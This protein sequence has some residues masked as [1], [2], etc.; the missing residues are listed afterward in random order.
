MYEC[1]YVSVFMYVRV[2]NMWV[3]TSLSLQPHSDYRLRTSAHS[4]VYYFDF[5]PATG[6]PSPYIISMIADL[7][8]F[9]RSSWFIDEACVA[10]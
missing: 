2:N 5:A 7:L 4:I 8:T 9:L 3:I 1:V 10:S 6:V